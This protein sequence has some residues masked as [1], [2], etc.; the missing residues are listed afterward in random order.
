VTVIIRA[1]RDALF[2][3][4]HRTML[5]IKAVG[6]KKLQLRAEVAQQQ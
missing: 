2:M 6:F 5:A 3:H 1:D 4:I